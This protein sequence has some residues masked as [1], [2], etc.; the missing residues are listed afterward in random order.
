[1]M[2]RLLLI[3]LCAS[4]AAQA[5]GG[6]AF[7]RTVAPRLQAVRVLRAEQDSLLSVLTTQLHLIDPELTC[8]LGT[9]KDGVFEMIVSADGVSRL[10]PTVRG[11]VETAP[12][13]PNWRFIAFRPRVGTSF[14][15]RYDGY[16]L[17]PDSLWFRPEPDSGRIGLWLYLPGADDQNR[18]ERALGAAF[19]MLDM[20]I[21]ELDA[22][23]KIGFIEFREL[24]VHPSERGLQ[25]IAKL[26]PIV[27]R[28]P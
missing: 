15:V 11:L 26:A 5:Q 9:A 28:L 3:S 1:M 20:V 2:Q 16:N 6:P 27:E 12:T 8:E 23:T 24:P 13:I 10:I 18:R 7:W 21:G 14:T 4:S 19:I 25:P 22:M 17:S